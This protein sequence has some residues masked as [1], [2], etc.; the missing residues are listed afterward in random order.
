MF[1]NTRAISLSLAS[2]SF[3]RLPS[4]YSSPLVM[5]SSPATILN[6][7]D[8]PHPKGPANTMNSW[9]LI[10][11][12]KFSTAITP[13]SVSFQL[14]LFFSMFFLILLLPFHF[15][16]APHTVDYRTTHNHAFMLEPT[17]YM[18][19]MICINRITDLPRDQLLQS[20]SLFEDGNIMEPI[21]FGFTEFATRN[22]ENEITQFAGNA[23][24]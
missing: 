16:L 5:S 3:I 1:W 21:D 18:V 23:F 22:P 14:C 17:G 13:S 7:A 2:T 8:F 12:L 10:V 9:S 6:A 24:K 11:R 19:R 20:D 4:M 15:L